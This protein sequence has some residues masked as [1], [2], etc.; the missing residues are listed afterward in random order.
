MTTREF[1]A[2]QRFNVPGGLSCPLCFRPSS[3]AIVG[4]FYYCRDGCAAWFRFLPET[5]D[6]LAT[7]E[8]VQAVPTERCKCGKYNGGGPCFTCNEQER[9]DARAAVR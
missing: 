9:L 7:L 5:P 2:A 1:P 8:R 3:L 6:R 4:G